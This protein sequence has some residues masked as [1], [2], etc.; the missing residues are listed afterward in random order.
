[1]LPTL[2][3]IP[4]H[5][6]CPRAGRLPSRQHRFLGV[7]GRHRQPDRN[8]GEQPGLGRRSRRALLDGTSESDT[9]DYAADPHG[10]VIPLDSHIRLANPRTRATARQRIARRSYNY[11]LGIDQNGNLQAGHIFIAYQQDIQRQFETIQR[12]LLNE[13]LVDYVQ[14]FGGG[15]FFTLPGVRDATDSYGQGLLQ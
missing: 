10:H 4:G 7:Q 5:L 2:R 6:R 14:P 1:M 9:P 3:R 15:Y 11:D 12:R 8:A 13:P